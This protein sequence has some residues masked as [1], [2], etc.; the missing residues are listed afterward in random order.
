[1][2]LSLL[3][4]VYFI[5][6]NCSRS[7]GS[8]KYADNNQNHHSLIRS[9]LFYPSLCSLSRKRR[10]IYPVSCFMELLLGSDKS[11]F[12][13]L[14]GSKVRVS[15]S[16]I[17]SHP[18]SSLAVSRLYNPVCDCTIKQTLWK[19]GGCFEESSIITSECSSFREKHNINVFPCYF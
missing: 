13:G 10:K 2:K 9:G 5:F 11:S 6:F 3:Q 12:Q 14:L 1:M 7:L 8:P 17:S 16:V 15:Q 19:N 4:L 18:S